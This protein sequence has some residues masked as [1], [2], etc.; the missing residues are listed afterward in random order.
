[1]LE[2]CSKRC[3]FFNETVFSSF[4]N[5][6]KFYPLAPVKITETIPASDHTTYENETISLACY[7]VGD[8]TPTVVWT[9]VGGKEIID[10]FYEQK[11]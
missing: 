4:I 2:N 3:L 11:K 8:P 1:M 10:R 6:A 7:I 9:K 5:P